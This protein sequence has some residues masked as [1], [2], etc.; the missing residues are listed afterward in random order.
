MRISSKADLSGFEFLSYFTEEELSELKTMLF[1][2][3][4]KKN[5]LLFT[6]GDHRERIFLL[7]GGY[8][9]LEKTNRDANMLYINYISPNDFF[10]YVGLF[11]ES[12]YRYS[13]YAVTD[14]HV[15][16]IPAKKFEAM[17]PHKKELLLHI[18]KRLDL[19]TRRHQDRLQ[20]ISTDRKS[21]V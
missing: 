18:I 20:T 5:Q 16:Y 12:F 19:L 13:A 10:P 17:I 21:V 2:R 11:N 14:I 1:E 9:K 3:T 15:Y 6:E 7:A 4:Y 8:V